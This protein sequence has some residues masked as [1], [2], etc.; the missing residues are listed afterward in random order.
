VSAAD[1]LLLATWSPSIFRVNH[2]GVTQ[3]KG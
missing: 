2:C 1:A 3:S